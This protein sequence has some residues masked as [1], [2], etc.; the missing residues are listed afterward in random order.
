MNEQKV[1]LFFQF[2]SEKK[3]TLRLCQPGAGSDENISKGFLLFITEISF[4]GN[5]PAVDRVPP[6]VPMIFLPLSV[7]I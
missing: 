2:F 5:P 6:A 4:G 7:S 3:L 1:C